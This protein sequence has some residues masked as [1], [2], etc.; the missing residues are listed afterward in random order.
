MLFL[1]RRTEESA[2]YF[3]SRE[4]VFGRATNLK[5]ERGRTRANRGWNSR[6]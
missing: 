4:R 5:R 2:I 6:D 3:R 1:L